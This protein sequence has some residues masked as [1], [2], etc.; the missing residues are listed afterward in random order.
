MSRPRRGPWRLALLTLALALALG[1]RAEAREI[2][3]IVVHATGGP[4]CKNGRL[5]HSPS[6]TL[7]SM[8][9]YFAANPGIGYHYLIGRDGTLVAGVPETEIAHHARG[10]NPRSIGIELIND[11]DGKD[12]FPEAQIDTLIG[13]L[14]RLTKTYDL[15]PK[16]IKSHSAVDSRSF[17][18]GG[19][20]YK[21]KIDPGGEYPGSKGNFPWERVRKAVGGE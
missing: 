14:K 21:Q 20:R 7:E 17:E 4:G 16:Q 19:R 5:W 15:T 6:G 10:H 9:R 13:L 8:Q 1:P 18:C 3:L 2:D 11:G 12:P